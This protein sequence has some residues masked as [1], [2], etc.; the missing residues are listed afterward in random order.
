MLYYVTKYNKFLKQQQYSSDNYSE[1]MANLQLWTKC[2][3]IRRNLR[4]HDTEMQ[5]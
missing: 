1:Q 2:H 3:L 4:Q 5:Y